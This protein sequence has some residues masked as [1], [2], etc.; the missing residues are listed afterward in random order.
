MK[1]LAS[2][3]ITLL[4][5]T[6]FS[7]DYKKLPDDE[8]VQ[9]AENGDDVAQYQLGMLLMELGLRNEKNR[10]DYIERDYFK[11]FELSA[12]QNNA[13]SL[14]RIGKEYLSSFGHY[15]VQDYKKAVELL[16]KASSESEALLLLATL[17]YH[18]L[19]TSQ[20]NETAIL[21]LKESQIDFYRVKPMLYLEQEL[22]NMVRDLSKLENP[23]ALFILGDFYYNGRTEIYIKDYE[24]AFRIF[25]QSAELGSSSAAYMVGSMLYKGT[26]VLKNLVE[27]YSWISKATELGHIEATSK[28]GVMS[29]FAEGT[30]R[31]IPMAF[32]LFTIAAKEENPLSQYF[33]GVMY[34]RGEGTEKN[35]SESKKWI[36]RAYKNGSTTAKKFWDAKELWKIIDPE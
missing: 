12:E 17:T 35:R 26:G 31:D 9:L 16:S 28:A 3:L 19:G 2:L 36:E 13:K 21:Y 25:K 30:E 15:G 11:W 32:D 27:S 14:L 1:L 5:T 7:M 22:V 6:L 10:L 29:Y 23:D 20:N 18:G 4:T 33:L 34:Y 8:L 24:K